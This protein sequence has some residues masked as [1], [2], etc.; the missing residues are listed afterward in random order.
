MQL[1]STDFNSKEYYPNIRKAVVSGYFMQARAGASAGCKL[2]AAGSTAGGVNPPACPL[3]LHAAWL[4]AGRAGAH[5]RPDLPSLG[6]SRR[7]RTWSAQ[8]TT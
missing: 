7:W 6:V 5:A 8:G 2:E 3:A 4:H 1:V